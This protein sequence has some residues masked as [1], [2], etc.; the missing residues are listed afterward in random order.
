MPAAPSSGGIYVAQGA[1][2]LP[3]TAAATSTIG[4]SNAMTFGDDP[5][6]G[7]SQESWYDWFY[8]VLNAPG[9]SSNLVEGA[10]KA[11][12][13]IY[14]Y[15]NPLLD[16]GKPLIWGGLPNDDGEFV[17]ERWANVNEMKRGANGQLDQLA[18]SEA[19]ALKANF[20]RVIGGPKSFKSFK[21]LKKELGS[22]GEG[23][24][25]HHIVEQRG[26]NTARFGV[27][28]IQST[29]NVIAI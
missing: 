13:D 28:K 26:P 18:K 23:N 10:P 5:A 22:P 25:W 19:Q 27:A 15:F 21:A 6:A 3:G 12:I 7:G 4:A 14:E 24:V 16:S 11:K 2:T 17:E 20:K 9:D 1:V 29:E 8:R